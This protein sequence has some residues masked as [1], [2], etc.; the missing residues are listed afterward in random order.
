M[1]RIAAALASLLFSSACGPTNFKSFCELS[2][3][4]GCRQSFRCKPDESKTAFT[5]QATCATTLKSRARCDAFDT[6]MTC[7]LNGGATAKCLSDI[8]NAPCTSTAGALP[9]SCRSITCT[10]DGVRCTSVTSDSSSGGC[11]YTLSDC[12][13]QNQYGVQCVGSSCSCQKNASAERQ[14]TGSCA[15]NST[16]RLTQLKAE[17]SYDLK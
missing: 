1:I 14:F 10:G 17:C 9:E 5:D 2:A 3:E 4:A 15:M 11:S 8:Q 12:S 16:D 13:D 7:V 6:Q